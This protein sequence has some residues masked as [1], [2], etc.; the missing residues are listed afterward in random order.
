MPRQTKPTA[1]QR[2]VDALDDGAAAD[3]ITTDMGIAHDHGDGDKTHVHRLGN[4]EH[5]HTDDGQAV[6]EDSRGIGHVDDGR[7]V[8][9]DTG[10][11][12]AALVNRADNGHG[13]HLDVTITEMVTGLASLAEQTRV[14]DLLRDELGH[15]VG[16]GQTLVRMTAQTADRR[17]VD[18]DL[19]RELK[20]RLDAWAVQRGL[21][22]PVENSDGG[23]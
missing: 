19:L 20:V 10:P 3:D 6:F 12:L 8:R 4:V 7:P 18:P 22:K 13:H 14:A 23:S 11:P 1:A 2:R 21:L 17:L 9:T 5:T 15:I 16:F